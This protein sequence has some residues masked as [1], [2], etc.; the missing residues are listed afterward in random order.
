MLRFPDPSVMI[1]EVESLERLYVDPTDRERL[2]EVLRREREVKDF[3]TRLLGFD[4]GL[5]WVNLSVQ[6]S[7]ET[8]DGLQLSGSVVDISR[9]REAEHL[10]RFHANF[11][12]LTGLPNRWQFEQQL[13]LALGD[14]RERGTHD[15]AVLFLDLDGF[16]WVNDSL[17]HG[18]GDRLLVAI[19]ERLSKRLGREALLARYGGDEFSLLPHGPCPRERALELAAQ[20]TDLFARP[21]RVDG[22][23][24]Y[25]G[26]SLGIVLGHSDYR[27][28]EQLLR[29]ADTAMYRAK[30]A[31][32]SGSVVFDDAM[33]AEVRHRFELQTDLRLALSRSEFVVYFQPIVDLAT[34]DTLGCEAL[35]RWQ[36]PR[37]GLLLP[38][39]FLSLAEETGLIG[40]IDL[41]MLQTAS[42]QVAKWR[43]RPGAERL[44]LNINMDERLVAAADAPVLVLE[45]LARS[46]LPAADLHIEVTERVF[47]A[48]FS[49]TSERLAGL[50]STGA[51]LVV[52]DFGT[53]Y[54]S[55]DSFAQSPFD[56]LKIDRSFIRDMLGNVRHRAIV[57]TIV[58]FAR[59]LG[60]N[61]T[62]EGVETEAQNALL[63]DMGCRRGQGHLYAMAMPADE[64]ERWLQR[65]AR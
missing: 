5:L 46:G 1:R 41:W 53:G 50:K 25:S 51:A 38:C 60:L 62:A 16:K 17:G 52:D 56:A 35:V 29:D 44:S 3:S 4:G 47:R 22:Q 18:A 49:Q 33:H 19:S 42:A 2:L 36:H 63:L 7:T 11:D 13:L 32:K 24:V 30:L 6:I 23:E 26:A 58:S 8:A 59:D 10:L 20:V 64:F 37:R 55:L 21:F 9:Q 28:P 27:W 48:D 61:L 54:S 57:H 39:E 45:A 15:Y 34:G 65:Q 14:A 40:E 31:G 43:Q 12:A